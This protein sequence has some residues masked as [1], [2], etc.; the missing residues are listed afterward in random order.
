MGTERLEADQ[1]LKAL[2]ERYRAD[3]R[4]AFWCIAYLGA[5][6]AL[7]GAWKWAA[8]SECREAGFS[9]LYCARR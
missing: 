1:H 8:W 5:A 6:L 3:R 9:I 7:G 4:K 2:E